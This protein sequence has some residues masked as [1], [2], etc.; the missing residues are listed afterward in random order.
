MHNLRNY[1]KDKTVS[2]VFMHMGPKAMKSLVEMRQDPKGRGIQTLQ[3]R[4]TTSFACI[5]NRNI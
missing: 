1:K 4:T 2:A 5:P 3:L